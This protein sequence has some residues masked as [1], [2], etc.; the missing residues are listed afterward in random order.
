MLHKLGTFLDNLIDRQI[1]EIVSAFNGHTHNSNAGSGGGTVDHTTLSTIGTKTHAQI[2]TH[3]ASTA[4]PHTVTLQQAAEAGAT[5]TSDVTF[6]GRAILPMGEVSYFSMTGTAIAI[7][8]SSDGSSNMVMA[9]PA[10]TL[11]M[12]TGFDN[13]GANNGRL[14]YIGTATKMFHVA[15][16]ISI[17]PA[18]ANDVFV[19]G[20]AKNGTVV[21]ASKI[22]LQA[23]NASQA[24]STA[25]H[26]MV[27]LA[28][29]DYI[30]LYIGNTTD[31]DDCTVHSLNLF[32]MGM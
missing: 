1:Q 23:I 22:L 29:N 18:A 12:D 30:E 21:S 16:T 17:A 31:A 7:A 24:R 19:F 3:I 32:A 6:S 20:I 25:M 11:N 4:N 9:N 27:E 15:C 8:A 13:G 10:T 14:R 28:T 5:I 2:D 26:V